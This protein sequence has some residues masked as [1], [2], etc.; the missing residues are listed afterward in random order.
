MMTNIRKFLL[1]IV[2]LISVS[3]LNGQPPCIPETGSRAS[4]TVT[5]TSTQDGV[6]VTNQNKACGN[7]FAQG[8]GT[9]EI[10]LKDGSVLTVTSEDV[11]DAN[12]GLA[13]SFSQSIAEI[14]ENGDVAALTQSFG[15]VIGTGEVQAAS[16]AIALSAQYK[17][18]LLLQ[19]L[20]ALMILFLFR[21][22]F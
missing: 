19:L 16:E 1:A 14:S 9:A 4:S 17:L 18:Q 8:S 22:F 6:E 3:L 2:L 15:L 7:A 21:F 11:V 5:A 13:E 10:V 20:L 12:G